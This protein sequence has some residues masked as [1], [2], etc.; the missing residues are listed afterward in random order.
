MPAGPARLVRGMIRPAHGGRCVTIPAG[1]GPGRG[2]RARE[3]RAGYGRHR[4]RRRDALT[5]EFLGCHSRLAVNEGGGGGISGNGG[6]AAAGADVHDA[7]RFSCAHAREHGRPAPDPNDVRVRRRQ[8]KAAGPSR[9]AREYGA[10]LAL[11]T[12][13]LIQPCRTSG[14][15]AIRRK[16]RWS[17]TT[18]GPAGTPPGPAPRGGRERTAPRRQDPMSAGGIGKPGR[19]RADSRRS[20]RDDHNAAGRSRGFRSRIAARRRASGSSGP[21]RKGQPAAVSGPSLN[22]HSYAAW[23]PPAGY[24]AGFV[25]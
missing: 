23:R 20:A 21:A 2:K 4:G 1:H 13:A 14:T 24:R 7:A 9:P 11:L 15:A 17:V 16:L 18:A 22:R 3:P 6:P 12:A 10:A 25:R 8:A 5:C 19:P